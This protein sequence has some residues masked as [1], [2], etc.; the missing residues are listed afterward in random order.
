MYTSRGLF[1]LKYFFSSQLK[2]KRGAHCSSTATKALIKKMI[3][4]E[5]VTHP[6]SDHQLTLLLNQHGIKIARRTVSKYREALSIL[7]SN[8]RKHRL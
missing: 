8:D 6:L 4:E 2:T 5:N 7:P 3:K 1:E